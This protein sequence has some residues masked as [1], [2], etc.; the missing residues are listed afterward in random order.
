MIPGFGAFL[1]TSS[2]T[3]TWVRPTEPALEGELCQLCVLKELNPQSQICSQEGWNVCVSFICPFKNNWETQLA[4]ALEL[5]VWYLASK[6]TSTINKPFMECKFQR[7]WPS[8]LTFKSSGRC[9]IFFSFPKQQNSIW[10]CL[11][12]KHVKTMLPYCSPFISVVIVIIIPCDGACY[13]AN[14]VWM[15]PLLPPCWCD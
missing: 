8:S 13:M 3:D 4:F 10:A 12:E 15:T 5:N 6:W 9:V 14:H 11:E 7:E 1:K 2:I